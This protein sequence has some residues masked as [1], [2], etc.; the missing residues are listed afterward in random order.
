MIVKKDSDLN[1]YKERGQ[2]VSDPACCSVGGSEEKTEPSV[3][4]CCA[5][6]V[7]ASGSDPETSTP[8]TS[9]REI[10]IEDV[11]FNEWVSKY[12]FFPMMFSC[13]PC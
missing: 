5:S 8:A 13:F 3:S 10:K 4:A 9:D 12:L 7:Q 6:S 2:Q 11:D 1:I